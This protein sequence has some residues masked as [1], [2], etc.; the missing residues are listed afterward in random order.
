MSGRLVLLVP[1]EINMTKE[2]SIKGIKAEIIEKL[3]NNMDILQYLEVEKFIDEGYTISK[4]YNNL[5]YDYGVEYVG[6]NYISVEVAE[7]DSPVAI[8]IGNKKYTVVIKMGLVNERKVCDL[9]SIITDIVNKL[10]PDRKR[11]S[12]VAY[13]VIE[14]NI[15]AETYDYPM[16]TFINTTLNNNNSKQLHRM[17]KFEIGQ[18]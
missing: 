14:N 12:N 4:L 15:N 8:N 16:S 9:S 17:I 6:C 11:F 10:Y 3:M 2:L 1:L 13:R 7:F 5:I 18:C